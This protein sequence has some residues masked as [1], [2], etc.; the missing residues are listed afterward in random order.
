MPNAYVS[1]LSIYPLKSS[2]PIYQQSVKVLTSGLVGDRRFMLTQM[3]GKFITGR[4]HPKVRQIQCEYRDNQMILRHLSCDPL[5]LDNADFSSQYYATAV[6]GT[7]FLGQGCGYQADQWV[8]ALLE[9]PLRILYFGD[10]SNRS[11]V[12]YKDTQVGFADGYPLLLTNDQ[13][14]DHLNQRLIAPVSMENFRPNITLTGVPAWAEDEWQKIQIGDVVFELP[15]PCSRCI[16]TTLDPHSTTFD[17]NKDPLKTLASYRQAMDAKDVNFGENMVA[18]NEGVINVGDIIKVLETKAKPIY[19][20]HWPASNKRLTKQLAISSEQPKNSAQM[21]LRCINTVQETSDVKTFVFSADPIQ[22]FT[23]LPGQFITINAQI[24]NTA[25]K[26]CY[27]LSSSPSKPDTISITVKRVKGGVV[28]NWLHDH[29][30]IGS[31]LTAS[32]PTG[33]FH[34]HGDNRNK[35]LLLSAGSGITPMLSIIRYIND[36]ALSI[37]VHFHHSAK[38]E[39]DFIAY[40]ELI[41]AAERNDKITLSANYTRITTDQQVVNEHGMLDYSL[42]YLS[43]EAIIGHCPDFLSRDVFVCGPEGFMSTA[44]NMLLTA[45]LNIEQYSQESFVIDSSLIAQEEADQHY[46]VTFLLSDIEVDVAG[47]QTIL[48]AAEAAGI[49]PDYSC[50]SGVCGS[51]T[52]T[53]VSGKIHAPDALAIDVDDPDNTD[54]LPCCSYARSDLQ[55]EL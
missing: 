22:R 53:L 31:S 49:Y 36:L 15:K 19:I 2:A 41:T 10:K 50:L 16:F 11:V 20:D 6:W 1:S 4:T 18:L 27:T 34:L 8:S 28:S 38:T 17:S 5:I 40:A 30:A 12:G 13:S 55:V 54:F 23:Y 33:V 46:K 9:E 7:E 42:G 32:A 44:K 35:L 24:N 26:R 45:G 51:C 21:T 52:S 39:E 14:L 29:F 48:E 43:S 25:L 3:D 37:N 47:D